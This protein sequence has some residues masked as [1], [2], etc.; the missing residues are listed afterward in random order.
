[1]NCRRYEALVAMHVG[2]ELAPADVR[3]V[4]D[5]L[6]SC[7]SCRELEGALRE[8]RAL[9]AGGQGTEPRESDMAL[10]RR[11]VLARISSDKLRPR[12][13]D[14]VAMTRLSLGLRPTVGLA[15]ATLAASIFWIVSSRPLQKPAR[16]GLDSEGA[17]SAR[18]Q[19]G[20]P[21]PRGP[22]VNTERQEPAFVAGTVPRP[23]PP[24]VASRMPNRAVVPGPGRAVRGIN[25]AVRRI[26]IQT[27]AP[28]I[29]IIWL[30]QQPGWNR[31]RPERRESKG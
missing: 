30:C 8:D 28:N 7:A 27:A 11:N 18:V 19:T 26:E 31:T 25:P 16:V 29:R 23:G 6:D 10:M 3:R 12:L 24:A 2:G 1:M 4:A 5:H 15:A 21:A 14:R 9:L 13:R 22:E 17:P 20:R